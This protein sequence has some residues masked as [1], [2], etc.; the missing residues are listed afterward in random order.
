MGDKYPEITVFCGNDTCKWNSVN[1]ED[2][3]DGSYY[4]TQVSSIDLDPSGICISEE[5][6]IDN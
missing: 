6:D 3:V 5:L 1:N 2:Q 4:C